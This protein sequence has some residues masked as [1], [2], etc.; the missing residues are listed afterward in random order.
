VSRSD[1][2]TRVGSVPFVDL[3]AQHREVADEVAAGLAEVIA[4]TSFV[5]GPQVTAFEAQWAAYTDSRQA[6]GVASGTD[7]LE[8]A[9]RAAGLRAGDGVVVPTNSFVASAG[10]VARAGMRPVLV[11]CDDTYH[12][13]DPDGLERA[14]TDPGVRAVMPVHLFGQMAPVEQI[15]ARLGDRPVVVVEDAAQ[16][17]GARRHGRPPGSGAGTGSGTG[18]R[19]GVAAWSFYPG[20][21]LGAYGDAGA[22]TTGDGALAAR[23]RALANH[24]RAAPHDGATG[25]RSAHHAHVAPGFTARLDSIQAVVLSAKLARLEAWNALRRRCAARYDEL[26]AGIDGVRL[27]AVMPGNEA[28][29]H[30]YVV[31]VRHR[32]RVLAALGAAGVA[33]GVHYPV[34]IHLVPAFRHLGHGPGDFPVAEGMAGELLSL[35]MY[36]HLTEDQQARVAEVVAGALH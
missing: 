24:G 27:P 9:L 6:V 1:A 20:K 8:L 3:A 25:G 32:D 13:M 22:V 7:A 10:A 12:L 5:G 21:N 30:L 26:L 17:H 23:V 19:P 14:L 4:A 33:A 16:A 28:V 34:P 15:A 29:W 35:P 18:A 2:S 36:P 11:D 31:R